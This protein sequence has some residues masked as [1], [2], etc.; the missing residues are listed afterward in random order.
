MHIEHDCHTDLALA[1]R[2][3][4][5]LSRHDLLLRMLCRVTWQHLSYLL[6]LLQYE[7]LQSRDQHQH[8]L[9]NL[10]HEQLTTAIQPITAS[11]HSMLQWQLPSQPLNFTDLWPIPNYTAW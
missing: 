10:W 9:L 5:K 8:Q 2:C 11:R 7:S 3:H 1:M 4:L 6:K